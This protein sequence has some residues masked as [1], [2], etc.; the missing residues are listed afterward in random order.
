MVADNSA[1]CRRFGGSGGVGGL[2]A[3]GGLVLVVLATTVTGLGALR[4]LDFALGDRG[5][6]LHYTWKAD[7]KVLPIL[8]VLSPSMIH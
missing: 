3:Q 6:L 5:V 8:L 7:F 4:R 1:E 2:G